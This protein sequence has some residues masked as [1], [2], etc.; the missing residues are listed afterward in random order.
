MRLEPTRRD[1]HAADRE[2]E[3]RRPTPPPPSSHP[4]LTLQ[5]FAGNAAVARWV[6]NANGGG[7]SLARAI[8]IKGKK[9]VSFSNYAAFVKSDVYQ[10]L[11][12]PLL[13]QH[14]AERVEFHLKQLFSVDPDPAY[15]SEEHFV[16]ALLYDVENKSVS[17]EEHTLQEQYMTSYGWD[18]R[19]SAQPTAKATSPPRRGQGEKSKP[20]GEKFQ[21]PAEDAPALKIYRTMKLVHWEALDKGDVS[22]LTGHLGDFKQAHNYLHRRSPEP[23]VLVEFTLRPGAERHLFGSSVMAFP[24]VPGPRKAPNIIKGTLEKEG[25]KGGFAVASKNEGLAPGKVGVKSEHGES[26]FSFGIGGH[27][28]AKLFMGLVAGTKVI[29]TSK[30]DKS[31]K[32]EEDPFA[33]KDRSELEGNSQ[34]EGDLPKASTDGGGKSEGS[35]K[36]EKGGDSRHARWQAFL[37]A[38]AQVPVVIEPVDERVEAADPENQF[39]QLDEGEPQ[40]GKGSGSKAKR[41]E[42]SSILVTRNAGGGDCL[43]HALAGRDL[44][45]QELLVVRQ[46]IAAIRDG[47]GENQVLNALHV[48]AALTQTGDGADAHMIEGRHNIPDTVYALLQAVPG[49]Y[50]GDDELIQ[51]CRHHNRRV[52]VMDPSQPLANGALAVF[53]PE[54]RDVVPCTEENLWDRAR[55]WANSTPVLYK[56]PGHWERV[57]QING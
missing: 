27:S 22:K 3:R 47:T 25:E 39:A 14:P 13:K 34:D 48:A 41:Y 52:T 36:A 7:R 51:W 43:F 15:E 29:G 38:L 49:I 10:R 30:V 56:T 11:V 55:Y 57:T 54:G 35:Q 16:E 33:I 9:T 21:P 8:R 20:K 2:L 45:E 42:A 26:G 37:D 24:N 6:G 12:V 23:K 53:S 31:A 46:T 18:K 5:R 19:Q 32:E 17:G 44:S 50:A 1:G 4:L 28:S 40:K